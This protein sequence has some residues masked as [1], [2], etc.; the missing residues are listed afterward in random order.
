MLLYI[1][2]NDMVAHVDVY[3]M[4]DNLSLDIKLS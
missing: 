2:F 3:T 4:M 1:I